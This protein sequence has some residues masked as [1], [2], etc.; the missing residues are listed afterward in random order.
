MRRATAWSRRRTPACPTRQPGRGL[1]KPRRLSAPMP[2]SGTG[3]A[4]RVHQ[5]PSFFRDLSDR[6]VMCGLGAP[7]G[8]ITGIWLTRRSRRAGVSGRASKKNPKTSSAGRP[9][10]KVDAPGDRVTARQFVR[11]E[12]LEPL[13]LRRRQR[14]AVHVQIRALG[15]GGLDELPGVVRLFPDNDLVLERVPPQRVRVFFVGQRLV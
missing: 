10:A 9:A 12:H 15:L 5:L 2:L 1:S 7:A 13:D 14:L 11:H 4:R 6:A 3:H 8:A